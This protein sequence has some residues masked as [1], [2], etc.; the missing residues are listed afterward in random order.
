MQAHQ[1]ARRVVDVHQQ[2][3]RRRAFLEPAMVA[4]VDLDQLAQTCAPRTRLVDLRWTLPA[5]YPQAR[6]RHQPSDRFPG[7]ANA[8]ALVQLLAG[9]R[10]AKVGI[11][12]TDDR[13]RPLGQI[14]VQ[15]PV[16]LAATLAR[17]QSS[18]A[19]FLVSDHQ[20]LDLPHSQTQ[21]FSRASGLQPHVHHS[22]DHLQPVEF[23]HVQCHQC[24]WMHRRL[25]SPTRNRQA[26]R[27]PNTTFLNG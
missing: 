16:T 11:A 27:G 7:Q 1:P 18:R 15:T 12:L 8:V 22:L 5:R 14:L 19:R 17:G 13:Q 24:G 10:R 26:Y 25:R 23:A 4:A 6:V 3:T 21:P 2:R 20:T 9:Q